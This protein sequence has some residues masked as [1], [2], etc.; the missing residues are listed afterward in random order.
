MKNRMFQGAYGI[1]PTPF[2]EDG[3]VDYN[4]VERMADRLCGTELAGIVEIGRAHV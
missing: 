3:K 4:Q 1:I 2:R